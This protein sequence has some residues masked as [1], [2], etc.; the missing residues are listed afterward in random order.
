ML[1]TFTA[2]TQGLVQP[3]GG[4][5][6]NYLRADGTWAVPPVSGPAG[7][8]LAGTYPNPTV[9]G[10]KG[11]P[12]PALASGFL[13]WTGS[14]W[15]FTISP[16]ILPT[17][18]ATVLGGV[19]PDGTSIANAAGVISLGTS[20][21]LAIT[22]S[23]NQTF[24]GHNLGSGTKASGACYATIKRT[25]ASGYQWSYGEGVGSVAAQH[26]GVVCDSI[27]SIPAYDIDGNTNIVLFNGGINLASGKV[28][29]ANGVQ[30]LTAQQTGI[31]ATIGAYT[32]SGTYATDL[33]KLQALY[34]QVLALVAALKVHGLVAT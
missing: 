6:V 16:Y 13:N 31:G 4:G 11:Q 19:K 33:A 8:D 21:T 24:N 34:N 9:S 22:W 10:I 28:V 23:G 29:Q 7:G 20:Q 3:S 15:A 25:D 5:S 14:A 30:V 12:V 18:T 17:A 27:T 26:F 2:T 32:L 1:S